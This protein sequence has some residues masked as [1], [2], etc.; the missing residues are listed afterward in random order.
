MTL[1]KGSALPER[2]AS[3]KSSSSSDTMQHLKSGQFELLDMAGAY[4]H[5]NNRFSSQTLR[6][7]LDLNLQGAKPDEAYSSPC[8]KLVPVNAEHATHNPSDLSIKG[9][10]IDVSN[11]S[12]SLFLPGVNQRL[13]LLSPIW[14]T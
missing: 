9:V 7:V 5:N 2:T 14:R 6:I 10:E 13:A 3:V 1:G 4:L 8:F 12:S 11:D